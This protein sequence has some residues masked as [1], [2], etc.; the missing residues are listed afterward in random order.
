MGA[1][2]MVDEESQDVASAPAGG[3]PVN[4]DRLRDPD[5]IDGEAAIRVER[6][7][8]GEARG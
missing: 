5:V 8:A 7:G 3:A 6:R 4:R 1:S 2:T